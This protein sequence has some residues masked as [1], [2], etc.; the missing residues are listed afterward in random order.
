M[1]SDLI[2]MS[3]MEAALSDVKMM[4]PEAKPEITLI[5]GSGWND[6]V[7]SF[8]IKQE[9][10][11]QEISG[12][13]K[14]GVIGH[15]GKLVLAEYKGQEIFI[16]QGRRH[17]YEG[18]GWTPVLIPL[19]I[20]KHC[21]CSKILLTNSAGGI[22]YNPGELMIINGHINNMFANPLIG[23]HY[24]KLGPR[25]P[26]Q[27][28]TYSRK[29]IEKIKA[30]ADDIKLDIQEGVYIATT[31]PSYETPPEIKAY[32]MLGADAVGMSTVP[33]AIV[34]NSMGMKVAAISC[35]TNSAAGISN[36]PLS[37][38][39]VIETMDIIMPK[40]KLLMPK[41]VEKLI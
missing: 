14:S 41:I 40:M 21:G 17:W 8:D 23:P 34:A 13:G 9:I 16:F 39:E 27:S 11:F 31:G 25:F 29:L 15:A 37:H 10:Q 22:S 7:A 32:K 30:A 1:N 38:N 26:D 35:I 5:L 4:L 3:V 18:V 24:E 33:E 36:S 28:E 12:L 2:N 20:S 19:F 6:V